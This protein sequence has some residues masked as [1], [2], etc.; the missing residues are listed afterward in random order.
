MVWSIRHTNTKAFE[1]AVKFIP[2]PPALSDI[3]N[4]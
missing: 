4:T 3:N 1:A 2:T